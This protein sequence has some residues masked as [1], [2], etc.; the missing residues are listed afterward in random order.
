MTIALLMLAGTCAGL[1]LAAYLGRDF[2]ASPPFSASMPFKYLRSAI[3]SSKGKIV[4]VD[5]GERRL[6][7]LDVNARLSFLAKG[8]QRKNGFYSGRPIGFDSLGRFYIDNTV[9]DMASFNTAQR[10]I[11]RFSGAGK[12]LGV[13]DQFSFEDEAMSDWETHPVFTQMHADTLFWFKKDGDAWTLRS[14]SAFD[15]AALKAD[16]VQVFT[17]GDFNV[18]E[19]A[20]IAVLSPD[21]FYVLSKDGSLGRWTSAN[22]F[23]A[24]FD[25]AG[26]DTPIIRSPTGTAIDYQGRILVIDGKRLVYRFD[27][28]GDP[29][30]VPV[31]N[32]EIAKRGGYAGQIAFQE[33]AALP[34]GGFIMGNEFSGELLT[35]L[36]NGAISSVPAIEF[37]SS[38][39]ILNIV[40]WLS[41]TL[42]L[43]CAVSVLVIFYIKAFKKPSYLIVKQLLAFIPLI[44]LMVALVATYVYQGISELLEQQIKDRLQ[45]LAGIG[46]SRMSSDAIDTDQ[47]ETARFE[48]LLGSDSHKSIVSVLDELVNLNED[49]WNSYVF[50]YLYR[51]A[52]GVWWAM[53][54]FDYFEIYPYFKPEFERIMEKAEP[55][56]FKYSD[57][58]GSWLSAC[59]PVLR[60]DGSVAAVFEAS[61]SA[62][63]IDEAQ[64][65]YIKRAVVGGL[66]ILA[67]FLL[68]FGA[69]TGGL[70]RSIRVLK[71]GAARLASGDYE[72]EVKIHSRD[73]IEDLGQ[74]FNSMSREIK[75]YVSR[76]EVLN[77]A[78]SR[79]V[80][81]EFLSRLGRAS[82]T[83]IGLGDQV[84]TDMTILFSDIRDF[85]KLTEKLGPAGTMDFLNDYLSRMGPSVRANGGFVDKYVGDMIMALFP[86]STDGAV[87]SVLAMMDSLDLFRSELAAGGEWMVD[88]GF[89]LHSGPLMLGIIGEEERFEG[90]V[91]ADAVN[92]A[93]RI[94][95]L[96]KFYGVRALISGEVKEKLLRPRRLR[97][98][99][100]V[101]VKGKS[102]PAKLYE[103]I[104]GG[105]P[106]AKA[107]LASMVPYVR[108]FEE[109]SRSS[110]TEAAKSFTE[111]LQV[112]PG[113]RPAQILL[114]R[115]MKMFVSGAPADWKGVTEFHDK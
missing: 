37:G 74:S 28:R 40:I 81:S 50:P 67:A 106:A 42:S 72:V 47:V 112:A 8:E 52:G 57:V 90:T 14:I 39:K 97:F 51:K 53:G 25:N 75:T 85:T 101:H 66:A 31:L 6:L 93:S 77:R 36:P 95:S 113:D 20:D 29:I 108:G 98:I 111:A 7:G 33:I 1:G 9:L 43:L 59:A 102:R 73:E 54:S 99:D 13:V 70:L 26:I 58:Y 2:L 80:P 69:F 63:T 15:T 64:R 3:V 65:S 41:L 12:F 24:W 49:E 87:D 84:L 79:F 92:L 78:N 22:G 82:I 48:E 109:Y 23:E 83:E 105:D 27:P 91:I 115:C 94:E 45:H 11:L 76:L 96:T 55:I 62:N 34:N 10:Q 103:L 4:A 21:E 56:Y 100:I 16:K 86:E 44:V 61:M 32:P 38:F 18:Y 88:A 5:S 110:F 60:A 71:S 17:L 107:K 104:A 35:L 30:P 68:V 89:G 114:D 19:A 46:A